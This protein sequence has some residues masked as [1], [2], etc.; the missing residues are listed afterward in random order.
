MADSHSSAPPSGE[1][2]S[3]SGL[4]TAL[5]KLLG[6]EGAR[7]LREQLEEVIDEHDAAEAEDGVPSPPN[8]DLSPVERQMVRNLLHFSESDA[9]DVAFVKTAIDQLAA[10]G[11]P[12]EVLPK[13]GKFEV[14][15]NQF[16][17]EQD[18][19]AVLARLAPMGVTQGR[20]VRAR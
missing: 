6:L 9:D 13:D 17:T 10:K 7:S 1:A 20:V 4:I 15:I 14:R 12:T 5:R 8:G 2:D 3:S 18:A 19:R 16:A 11:Y